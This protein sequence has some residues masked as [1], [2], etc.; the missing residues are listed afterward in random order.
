MDYLYNLPDEDRE[1]EGFLRAS[2][3]A[4]SEFLKLKLEG[5]PA[6][7]IDKFITNAWWEHVENDDLTDEEANDLLTQIQDEKGGHIPYSPGWPARFAGLVEDTPLYRLELSVNV[8]VA[9]RHKRVYW[10]P[11]DALYARYHWQIL[12]ERVHTLT[13]EATPEAQHI[14]IPRLQAAIDWLKGYELRLATAQEMLAA[15]TT[16]LTWQGSKAELAELGYSL[17]ESGV[18][19]ATNRAAAVKSLGEVFGVALGDNP[20]THLQTIQKRKAGGLLTPLLDR[21]RD[22]FSQYMKR[23]DESEAERRTRRRGREN[24]A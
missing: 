22:A 23:K 24:T 9:D 11:V 3:Y 5:V 21:L 13:I 16:P 15:K 14:K 6:K 2:N 1:D 18:V 19:G 4:L 8:W 17:L 12:Q 10:R 7:E 20:A